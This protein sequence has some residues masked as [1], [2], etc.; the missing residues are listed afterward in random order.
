[1]LIRVSPTRF[2]LKECKDWVMDIKWHSSCVF[3]KISQKESDHLMTDAAHTINGKET[4][5]LLLL[6]CRKAV[7]RSRPSNL[8][9]ILSFNL[10]GFSR[11]HLTATDLVS[12][13]KE[14]STR[15]PITVQTAQ[16]SIC[17]DLYIARASK[18]DKC[19]FL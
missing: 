2:P 19:V 10:F 7:S 16:S 13:G 6:F 14:K 8:L 18:T 5:Y 17:H 1:M 15:S 11:G 12:D 3:R 4:C 9:L